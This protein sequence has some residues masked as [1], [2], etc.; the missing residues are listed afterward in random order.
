[1][2]QFHSLTLNVSEIILGT[3]KQGHVITQ[4]DTALCW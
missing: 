1:M 4:K 3:C 2:K